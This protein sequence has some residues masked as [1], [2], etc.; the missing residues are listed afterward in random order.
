[1]EHR[2]KK[3]DLATENTDT[4]N[5]IIAVRFKGNQQYYHFRTGGISVQ[6]G[7]AVIASTEKGID[8]G[9]VSFTSTQPENPKNL[10]T[11]LRKANDEDLQK[12]KENLELEIKARKTAQEEAASLKLKMTFQVCKYSLDKKRAT[13]YFTSE[14]RVDFRDLVKNLATKLHLRVELWQIGARDETRLFGGIGPCNR[15]LCCS[16]FYT[17]R[18]SVTVRDAKEQGLDINPQKITG[19]CGKLMCC[20]KF[21]VKEYKEK[22]KTLPANGETVRIEDREGRV[23]K[24]NPFVETIVVA[25]DDWS[26]QSFHA[27]EIKRKLGGEWVQCEHETKKK[28]EEKIEPLLGISI[29][30][31]SMEVK[32]VRETKNVS[33]P[34]P[35]PDKPKKI[36]TSEN[37][38]KKHRESQPKQ[39][40]FRRDSK[41][42]S[43]DPNKQN[44]NR[45][46]RNNQ[47]RKQKFKPKTQEPKKDNIR[48]EQVPDTNKNKSRKVNDINKY[49]SNRRR[50]KK[51]KKTEQS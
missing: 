1:M 39:N 10:K 19:M 37:K 14:K 15:E 2:D 18:E 30:N 13:L 3:N 34:T 28:E 9:Y 50:N 48:T 24:V 44:Q 43:H 40:R 33:P 12:L 45:D 7:Q 21:E 27:S 36:E 6:H 32:E 4:V 29:K 5:D 47:N 16:M 35:P 23:Q 49:L 31:N 26:V 25:F 46:N 38:D 22:L 17:S 11:I 20:L 51:E 41:E 42:K 8:L